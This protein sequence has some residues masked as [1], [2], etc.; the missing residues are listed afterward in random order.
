MGGPNLEVFKFSLYLFVPIAALVHFGDPEW[1]RKHVVPYRDRLFPS[2]ER[3]DQYI[4]KETAAIREEL[5]RI[6]AER[7][8]R[9]AVKEPEENNS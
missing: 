6:K 3:T 9:R 1:Y 2:A 5:A 8:A 7:L 4:P